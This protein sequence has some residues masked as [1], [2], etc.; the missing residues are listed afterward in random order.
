MTEETKQPEPPI[1]P[2][3]DS[4]GERAPAVH[5]EAADVLFQMFM[6][7]GCDPRSDEFRDRAAS[8]EIVSED[9]R[10]IVEALGRLHDMVELWYRQRH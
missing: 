9:E 6:Q 8:I 4:W 10:E 2:G 1:A 3:L 7:S 5:K